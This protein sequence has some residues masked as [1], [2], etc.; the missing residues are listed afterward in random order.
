MQSQ[1]PHTVRH[2]K[3]R[4]GGWGGGGPHEVLV[5]GDALRSAAHLQALAVHDF[6]C[7]LRLG[8]KPAW[9]GLA[10]SNDLQN[11]LHHLE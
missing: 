9:A 6:E 2:K 8:E 3:K 11:G 1:S 10:A 4:R 5:H 7:F